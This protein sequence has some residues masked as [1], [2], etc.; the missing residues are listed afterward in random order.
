M[1]KNTTRNATIVCGTDTELLAVDREE[2]YEFGL[3]DLFL[4]EC[5]YRI[6]FLR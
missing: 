3:Y 5:Q 2:F 4:K 1:L 6:D